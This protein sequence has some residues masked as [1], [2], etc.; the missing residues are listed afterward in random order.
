MH[1]T[2]ERPPHQKA[3]AREGNHRGR[4]EVVFPALYLDLSPLLEDSAMQKLVQGARLL[5]QLQDILERRKPGG[6]GGI[7]RAQHRCKR[8]GYVVE[9][10]RVVFQTRRSR[11]RE[12]LDQEEVDLVT[13]GRRLLF[14]VQ[15]VQQQCL[16]QLRRHQRGGLQELAQLVNLNTL[17]HVLQPLASLLDRLLRRLLD[18]CLQIDAGRQVNDE[19]AR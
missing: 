2:E 10:D 6:H 8:L 14:L 1:Q 7:D 13:V 16:Q 3:E 18:A 11:Q 12:K 5:C 17:V 9:R 4:L 19:L 15:M